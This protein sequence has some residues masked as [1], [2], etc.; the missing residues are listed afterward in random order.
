MMFDFENV[1]TRDF[2]ETI[3]ILAGL[4]RFVIADISN[5]R[6][7]P[8]ELQATVPD[9]EIPFLSIIQK[10]EQPFSMFSDLKNK[11]PWVLEPIEYDSEMQLLE[12]FEKVIIERALDRETEIFDIKMNSGKPIKNIRDLI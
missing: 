5:P 4:S 7:S 12:H 2:T 3:K 9:Y 11:Y 8:L 10:G 1:Q 6:S